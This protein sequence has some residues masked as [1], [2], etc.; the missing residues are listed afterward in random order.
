MPAKR[1]SFAVS[2]PL[3]LE[4]TNECGDFDQHRA[5]RVSRR[6]FSQRVVDVTIVIF[7]LCICSVSA[8]RF[9]VG[10]CHRYRTVIGPRSLLEPPQNDAEIQGCGIDATCLPLEQPN[11]I[12]DLVE[13][14][15]RWL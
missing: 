13:G 2:L 10:C 9:Q 7:V 12:A 4:Q 11:Q 5:E 14:A 8:R 3:S 1:S 15:V 6:K